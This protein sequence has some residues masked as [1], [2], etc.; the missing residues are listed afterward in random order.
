MTYGPAVAHLKLVCQQYNVLYL[1]L[2]AGRILK[3]VK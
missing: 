1:S 3:H 2:K